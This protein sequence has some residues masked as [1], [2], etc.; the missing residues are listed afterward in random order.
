MSKKINLGVYRRLDD[1]NLE[2]SEAEFL[3]MGLALHLKRKLALEEVFADQQVLQVSDWGETK[4]EKSHEFVQ[5]LLGI[6]GPAL[7]QYAIVPGLKFVGEKLADKLID[8]SISESVKWIISKL[9]PKQEAKEILDFHIQLPDGTRILV[10]PPDRNATINIQFLEG[11]V[12]SIKYDT[13]KD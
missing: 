3:K 8:D 12:E 7:V 13:L 1:G 4:D 11:K 10:D 9:R 6:V 5:L 2:L